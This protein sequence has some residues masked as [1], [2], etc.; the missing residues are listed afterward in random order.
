MNSPVKTYSLNRH[1]VCEIHSNALTIFNF[2]EISS[3]C[4]GTLKEQGVRSVIVDLGK[5]EMIDSVGVGLLARMKKHLEEK[6]TRMSICCVTDG[7]HQVFRLLDFHRR[8][9]I[10]PTVHEAAA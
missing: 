4:S 8:F 3:L 6:G 5:V 2:N 9:D 1:L 10:Y 7:V